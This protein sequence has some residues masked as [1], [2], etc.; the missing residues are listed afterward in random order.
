MATAKKRVYRTPIGQWSYVR[1]S[2]GAPRVATR[3][4][5]TWTAR[6]A[7]KSHFGAM[8]F[9]QQERFCV[10]T[11]DTKHQP[12]NWYTIHIGALDR[13]PCHP[14]DI[15]RPA[16]LDGAAAVLLAHNH[17]SGDST[18][19]DADRDVTKR[20]TDIGHLIGIQVLDSIVYGDGT[21]LATSIRDYS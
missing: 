6:E 21:G 1:E 11:M 2:A 18:P 10:L 12:L 8:P 3:I 9:T 16:I 17:P 5:D 7:V 14:A 20:L 13:C 19:S 4:T 15:F